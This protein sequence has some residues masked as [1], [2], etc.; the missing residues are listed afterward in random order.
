MQTIEPDGSKGLPIFGYS[1]Y[2]NV[3]VVAKLSIL[4]QNGGQH[5]G[6]QL[7]HSGR[8]AEAPCRTNVT[9]LPTGERDEYGEVSYY[10]AFNGLP[11][12]GKDGR[13]RRIPISTDCGAIHRVLLPNGITT[14][15]LCDANK[16]V[17]GSMIDIAEAICPFR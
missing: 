8:L 14:F 12:R 9:G 3:D 17:V 2:P 5:R 1:L 16:Y 11:Y 7:L 10:F 13:I 6:Q 4:L 15:R